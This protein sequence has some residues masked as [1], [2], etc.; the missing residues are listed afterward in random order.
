[1]KLPDQST[2]VELAGERSFERGREYFL[3]GQVLGFTDHGDR[4]EGLVFGTR[5]YRTGLRRE[6]ERVLSSCDC[7]VGEAGGF[8]KHAV[9]LGLRWLNGED[10]EK[11]VAACER[12]IEYA[13]NTLRQGFFA[14]WRRLE[15]PVLDEMLQSQVVRESLK[16]IEDAMSKVAEARSLQIEEGEGD[17]EWERMEEML[18]ER[19]VVAAGSRL[20]D[21]E[22]CARR[23]LSWQLK[24]A[25]AGFDAGR[26]S[27]KLYSGHGERW[28]DDWCPA[29]TRIPA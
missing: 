4:A 21:A 20:R 26:L 29:S 8:C 15:G 25:G 16:L 14:D 3:R 28:G 5:A 17:S 27:E 10:E 7:P 9:A 22:S 24:Q 6:A 13:V 2:L 19:H 1:M 12:L 18:C 11:S 23:V